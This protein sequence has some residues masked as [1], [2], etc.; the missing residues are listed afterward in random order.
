MY[1]IYII[2]NT[3]FSKDSTFVKSG[4]LINKYVLGIIRILI[5]V[6]GLNDQ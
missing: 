5:H 4:K 3:H 6:A 2:Y 1:I